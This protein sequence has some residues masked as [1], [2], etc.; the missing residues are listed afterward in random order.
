VGSVSLEIL[1]CEGMINA[2]RL[3]H[4]AIEPLTEFLYAKNRSSKEVFNFINSRS[5]MSPEQKEIFTF[6][7]LFR[8]IMSG[9]VA[10]LVDGESVGIVMGMQGFNF[11]SI[12]EP[13]YEANEL[14]GKEAFVEAVRINMSMVRRRIKSPNLRFEPLNA[15]FTSKTDICMAYLADRVSNKLI[16][17]VKKK[18]S[19]VNLDVILDSSYLRPYLENHPLSLFSTVGM[20]ERPDVLCGK[21]NEGRVALLVDG[22]PYALIVPFLFNE[23]FKSFDDYAHRPYFA[24][25][26][27][28][29]KYF[30]FYISFLLPGSYVAISTFHPE[31][32]PHALLFSVAGKPNRCKAEASTSSACRFVSE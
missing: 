12:S 13:T 14:G 2:E 6:E 8:F 16:K 10:I 9:F 11:R 26:V 23:N 18:I 15:G 21:I 17:E 31:L 24:S 3:A 22:S 29:L 28:L 32:L 19:K 30:S 25:F 1:S 7:E 20:T 4:A 5:A 27:R